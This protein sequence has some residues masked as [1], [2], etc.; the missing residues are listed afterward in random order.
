[1]LQRKVHKA[2][3]TGNDGRIF[4]SNHVTLERSFAEAVGWSLQQ[5][6]QTT[7]TTADQRSLDTVEQDITKAGQS[8]QTPAVNTA[9]ANNLLTLSAVLQQIMAGFNYAAS[10]KDQ[11]VIIT[12]TA[13]KLLSQNGC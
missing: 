1:M 5:P 6:Q 7:T 8:V 13:S 12:K 3:A 10:K 2:N 4:T 9:T 11:M